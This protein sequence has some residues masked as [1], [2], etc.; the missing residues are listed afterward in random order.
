M[1]LGQ[2]NIGNNVF[3]RVSYKLKQKRV[4][5]A[6]AQWV[7]ADGVFEGIVEPDFFEAAQRIIADRSRR[8]TDEELLE[9]LS[10]LLAE[11]GWLS[12]LVIDEMEDMP[13]SSTFRY[14]FGSLIRAYRLI[15]Y[16]PARD[17][18]YIETNRTLREL[19]PEIVGA[20]IGQIRDAGGAVEFDAPV[21]ANE[22]VG[23][24]SWGRICRTVQPDRQAP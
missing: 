24:E 11:R 2:Y 16:A 17:F 5:N 13:S 4:V 3:N 19:H 18:R 8:F 23:F 15:G 20:V 6:P 7:R 1:E 9:C 21:S 12:G 10:N 14:R 22:N